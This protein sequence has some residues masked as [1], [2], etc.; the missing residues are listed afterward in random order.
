MSLLESYEC[1]THC[2][3][4]RVETAIVEYFVK[5]MRKE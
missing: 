3:K 5:K 4:G 2:H 1:M